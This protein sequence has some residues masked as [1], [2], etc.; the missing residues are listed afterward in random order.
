VL[1][2]RDN[3]IIILKRGGGRAKIFGILEANGF[4][5]GFI[6]EIDYIPNT[7]HIYL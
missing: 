4:I 6:K 5:F 1:E 3:V 7:F 2:D